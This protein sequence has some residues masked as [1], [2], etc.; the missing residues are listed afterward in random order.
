[1]LKEKRT[2]WLVEDYVISRYNH[3]ARGDYN[4]EALIFK[5]G[6]RAIFDVSEEKKIE[7]AFARIITWAIILKQL[8]PSGPANIV[9]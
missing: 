9:K 2:H 8:F 4:T 1:M 6:N 7:N 3:P 5:M